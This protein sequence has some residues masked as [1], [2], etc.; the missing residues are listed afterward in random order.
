MHLSLPLSLVLSHGY[1]VESEYPPNLGYVNE[2][3]A[4]HRFATGR[5]KNRSLLRNAR[6]GHV[7]FHLGA[8]RTSGLASAPRAAGRH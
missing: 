6:L 3:S 2:P 7:I 8:A 5:R 1:F 4:M